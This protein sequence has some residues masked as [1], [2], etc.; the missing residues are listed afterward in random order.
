MKEVMGGGGKPVNKLDK[1]YSGVEE[2]VGH[3]YWLVLY[4]VVDL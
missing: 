4:F 3:E 2:S 1:Q